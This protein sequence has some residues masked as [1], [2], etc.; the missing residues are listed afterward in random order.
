MS[1]AGGFSRRPAGRVSSMYP[2]V[3]PGLGVHACILVCCETR[4]CCP[5]RPPRVVHIAFY[6]RLTERNCHVL[7]ASS[8][9]FCRGNVPLNASD[10]TFDFNR[11]FYHFSVPSCSCTMFTCYIVDSHKNSPRAA[12]FLLLPSSNAMSNTAVQ[13]HHYSYSCSGKGPGRS[14]D[15]FGAVSARGSMRYHWCLLPLA[16][17][18]ASSILTVLKLSTCIL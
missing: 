1:G 6:V 7:N 12:A 9:P 5:Q 8:L 10:K 4:W 11:N 16:I 14:I 15:C 17:D 18:R 2:G 3:C 13:N